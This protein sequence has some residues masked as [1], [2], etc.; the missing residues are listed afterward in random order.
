MAKVGPI[1]KNARYLLLEAN[2]ESVYLETSFISYLVARS[3]RDVIVAGHQQ[4]T[5]D[6]WENRR[7]LFS[8]S[9]SQIAIDEASVGDPSEVQKRL[10][11][12][13]GLPRLEVIEEAGRLCIRVL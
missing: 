6:W 13:S 12:T 8:C 9:V 10:A 1:G 4:T 7:S 5:H 3:S 2:M 11:V